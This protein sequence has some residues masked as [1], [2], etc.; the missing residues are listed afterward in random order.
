MTR[1]NLRVGP[2]CV[3]IYIHMRTYNIYIFIYSVLIPSRYRENISLVH[4]NIFTSTLCE[5]AWDTLQFWTIVLTTGEILVKFASFLRGF[6]DRNWR[7]NMHEISDSSWQSSGIFVTY[8]HICLLL[9]W[10]RGG[11]VVGAYRSDLQQLSVV[12]VM[13]LKYHLKNIVLSM[14]A[15]NDCKTNAFRSLWPCT[16]S[17]RSL[18]YSTTD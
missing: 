7:N 12:Y 16:L 14:I 4:T 10:I 18:K 9:I 2:I 1:T 3:C 8:N 5:C 17:Y 13:V 11:V 15:V 6:E